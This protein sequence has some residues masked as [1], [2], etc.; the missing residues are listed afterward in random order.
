MAYPDEGQLLSVGDPPSWIDQ[1]FLRQDPYAFDGLSLS[2]HEAACSLS[3]SLD[4]ER[5]G[6][7]C[8]GSGAVGLSINPANIRD[9][10]LKRYGTDSDLDIAVVSSRHFEMAWRELLLATQPHLKEVPEVVEQ[11]LSWQRKR[12]FDG[13]ILANKL[14]GTLSFGTVW[15]GAIDRVAGRLE[16][17]LDRPVSLEFWIYRDY[18]SL[19]N[20][21]ARGVVACQGALR[22]EGTSV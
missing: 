6:I 3:A 18:W 20:Y 13:A 12:L 14:L 4:V 5:N 10:H 22:L 11:H 9:G 16:D 2:F 7:F 17:V 15:Q 8:I 19:R 1:H 21:V